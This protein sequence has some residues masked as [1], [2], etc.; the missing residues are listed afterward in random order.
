MGKTSEAVTKCR[1]GFCKT[2]QG[3]PSL[4][5]PSIYPRVEIFVSKGFG[6]L[7]VIAFTLL[8]T[9]LGIPGN[10]EYLSAVGLVSA[11]TG[12]FQKSLYFGIVLSYN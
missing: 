6:L 5:R 12:S 10:A 9:I 7:N 3:C 2:L 1:M 4:H 8:S 11:C